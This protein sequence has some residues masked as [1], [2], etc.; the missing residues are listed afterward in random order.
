MWVLNFV[1]H[2]SFT[3]FRNYGEQLMVST[4]SLIHFLEVF[5]NDFDEVNLWTDSPR[6]ALKN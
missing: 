2:P 1:Y 4:F 6:M 3:A 5:P